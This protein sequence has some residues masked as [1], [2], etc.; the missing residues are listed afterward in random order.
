MLLEYHASLN[1]RVR[2]RNLTA[3]NTVQELK[4]AGSQNPP[5]FGLAQGKLFE[6]RE[7][8]GSLS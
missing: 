6:N 1:R 2:E 8:R 4:Q 5:P 7:D 3:E